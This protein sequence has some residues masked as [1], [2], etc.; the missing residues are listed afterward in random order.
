M[1]KFEALSRLFK[2]KELQ[3]TT[4]TV[5]KKAAQMI[6]VWRVYGAP[7]QHDRMMY[8]PLADPDLDEVQVN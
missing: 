3:V 7:K 5:R 4:T 2:F 1:K 8:E 6:C